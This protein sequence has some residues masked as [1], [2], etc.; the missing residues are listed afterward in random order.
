MSCIFIVRNAGELAFFSYKTFL[1]AKIIIILDIPDWIYV[2]HEII[3]FKNNNNFW[4]V[5]LNH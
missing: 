4:L 3:I 2:C 5:L 1:G